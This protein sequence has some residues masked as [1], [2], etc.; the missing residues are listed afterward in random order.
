MGTLRAAALIGRCGV[1]RASAAEV[2][3]TVN[4]TL[5]DSSVR[6]AR[7]ASTETPRDQSLPQTPA[8][9]RHAHTHTYTN[10]HTHTLIHWHSKPIPA[11]NADDWDDKRRLAG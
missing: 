3:V 5:R 1:R 8:N 4:T 9:V 6:A 11:W 7:L 10:T 2:C